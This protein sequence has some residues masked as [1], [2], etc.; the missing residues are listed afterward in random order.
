MTKLVNVGHVNAIMSIYEKLLSLPDW[1]FKEWD[2]QREKLKN[3]VAHMDKHAIDLPCTVKELKLSIEPVQN[4]VSFFDDWIEDDTR[5]GI[6]S[7]EV[8]LDKLADEANDLHVVHVN[9]IPRDEL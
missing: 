5:R 7:R 1:E 4:I 6:T 3:A 9:N 2:K 8:F